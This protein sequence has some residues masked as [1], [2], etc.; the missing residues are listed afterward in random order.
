M[1]KLDTVPLFMNLDY[2]PRNLTQPK[3]DKLIFLG[4][5]AER[6]ENIAVLKRIVIAQ[7][8]VWFLNK[9]N[10]YLGKDEN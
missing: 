3:L 10:G 4:E 6:T 2:W 9:N 7:L 8:K 5:R 1:K